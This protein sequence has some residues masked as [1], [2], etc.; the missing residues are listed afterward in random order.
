MPFLGFNIYVSTMGLDNPLNRGKT[1]TCAFTHNF[2]CEERI[3]Y[4]ILGLFVHAYASV[5]DS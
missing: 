1:K 5:S 2:C 3:K 4:L